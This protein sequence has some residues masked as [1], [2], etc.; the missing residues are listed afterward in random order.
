[1]YFSAGELWRT[2]FRTDSEASVPGG[3][4]GVSGWGGWRA[5]I[6]RPLEARAALLLLA[7]ACPEPLEEAN[8][9]SLAASTPFGFEG[10]RERGKGARETKVPGK[11]GRA[12]GRVGVEGGDVNIRDEMSVYG[13]SGKAGVGCL[14]T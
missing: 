6:A 12:V 4:A 1:M 3:R 5:I 13:A 9:N 11:T 2:L 7:T 8:T 14:T 10:E